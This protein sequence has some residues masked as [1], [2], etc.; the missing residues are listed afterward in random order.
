MPAIPEVLANREL[1]RLELAFV[2]FKATESGT[3]V[4]MLVYAYGS[5]R[6]Q[7]VTAMAAIVV[8]VGLPM[9]RSSRATISVV[10]TGP[11]LRLSIEDRE[12]SPTRNTCPRGTVAPRARPA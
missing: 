2:A 5:R 1:R 10:G 9:I 8:H 6:A 7:G 11:K 4:A 12:L 3:W